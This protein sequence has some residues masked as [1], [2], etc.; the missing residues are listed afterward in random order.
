MGYCVYSFSKSQVGAPCTPS[1]AGCRA[2]FFSDCVFKKT[3]IRGGGVTRYQVLDNNGRHTTV[4]SSIGPLIRE[5]N[6][7]IF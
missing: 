3:K 7:H 2:S 6:R 5:L 1:T 4:A